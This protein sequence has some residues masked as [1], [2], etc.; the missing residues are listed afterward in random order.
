ML[1]NTIR[2]PGL[3]E[4]M[5]ITFIPTP[6][7]VY[8][9][10]TL[11]CEDTSVNPPFDYDCAGAKWEA[12]VVSET[13][14]TP[15]SSVS[16]SASASCDQRS[17]RNLVAFFKCFEGG[18]AN[19][20]SPTKF[21]A[22]RPCAKRAGLDVDSIASCYSS[23]EN[24]TTVNNPVQQPF[25]EA[26]QSIIALGFPYV[27]I[28]NNLE[29]ANWPDL[30]SIVCNLQAAAADKAVVG[31]AGWETDAALPRGCEV[32][33]SSG[34]RLVVELR[35]P[36]VSINTFN[37]AV[38]AVAMMQAT[39]FIISDMTFPVRF[40][41]R[42]GKPG[43][44][45][46]IEMNVTRTVDVH[47][48]TAIIDPDVADDTGALGGMGGADETSANNGSKVSVR[49]SRGR[50][51]GVRVVANVSVLRATTHALRQGRHAGRRTFEAYIALALALVNVTVVDV[52][53]KR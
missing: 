37:A 24:A 47:S 18:F 40:T 9:N 2:A 38:F 20:D 42:A 22:A 7:P 12:C 36:G 45:S 6:F 39:N 5:D 4:V 13:C 14:G 33:G 1:E 3:A 48:I 41:D 27:K 50:G 34:R 16:S 21:A 17:Q 44:P 28:N 23:I 51:G 19:L 26:A 11:S 29:S 8:P 49:R 10:G 15:S 53:I 35:G 25:W 46:Y 30:L 43:T 31:A 32:D 52:H